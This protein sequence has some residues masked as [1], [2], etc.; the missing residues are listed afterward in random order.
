MSRYRLPQKGSKY[1]LPPEVY[2]YADRY[3]RMIKHWEKEKAW[4]EGEKKD[5]IG[6]KIQ[7]IIDAAE[8]VAPPALVPFLLESVT[9]GAT[10]DGLRASGMPCGQ[11]MLQDMRRRFYFEL[12]RMI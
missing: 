10:Y 11:H 7:V 8:K 5:A 2:E 3:A 4:A 9:S 12:S 6:A 1:Y